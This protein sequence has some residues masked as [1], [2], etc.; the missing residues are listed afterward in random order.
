MSS[1]S[2]DVNTEVFTNV[3]VGLT[4]IKTNYNRSYIKIQDVS[5]QVGGIIKFFLIII[6]SLLSFYSYVPY[7]ETLYGR[8]FDFN[9]VN[10][11]IKP[12]SNHLFSNTNN[13]IYNYNNNNSK[14]NF[15]ETNP[16]VND[17][18]TLNE[19]NLQ[20]AK[21]KFKPRTYNLYDVLFRCC[22]MNKNSQKYC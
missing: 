13:Y 10:E 16:V 21:Y 7:L 22:R 11:T 6:E 15:S 12:R 8:L 3:F 18:F 1:T 20:K 19:H 17:L 2:G 14:I 4:N 5:A 9:L